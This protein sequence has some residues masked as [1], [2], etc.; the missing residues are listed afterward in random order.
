MR[1]F[2]ILFLFLLAFSCLVPVSPTNRRA[3]VFLPAIP[4]LIG[5]L[6][7]LFEGYRIHIVPA[8]V[9]SGVLMLLALFRALYPGTG[10][11]RPIKPKPSAKRWRKG[12]RIFA[13][14]LLLA[15]SIVLP[16]LFP[17]AELPEPGGPYPVGT[18]LLSFRDGSR[19]EVYSAMEEN[20][21]IPVQVWYPAAG[22]TGRKPAEWI[23][24]RREAALFASYRHLP[25][26]FGQLAL[27]RTHSYWN[28]DISEAEG[29]YPVILFSDG[30]AM[31]TGQNTIQT[32]ELASRGYVV[33][34]VGHPYFDFAC[35]YP[36]GTIAPYSEKLAAMLSA[37]TANALKTARQEYNDERDP[38][39]SRAILRHAEFNK[40]CLR[41]WS[42]D[43]RFIADRIDDM[44]A[45]KISGLFAGKLD[46]QRM[47]AFGHSFGG[48]AAGQLCLEDDRIRAFINLDGSP[49]GDAPD[50][51][52]RQPFMILTHGGDEKYSIRNGYS[53][54]E[55]HFTV[56]EIQ[57]ARHMNFSDFNSLTPVVGRLAG[58]L[59]DVAPDRQTRIVNDYILSFFDR[60]LK[61][62]PVS[63]PDE[64][65][66]KYEEVTL[67]RY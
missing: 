51:N 5:L 29:S 47:G 64:A 9:L 52:I 48:A 35:T 63:L 61:D 16:L 32:E 21:N 38:E 31:F 54:E 2:E 1:Y 57:G 11:G 28:A 55:D 4:F 3:G 15:V 13:M 59:G 66:R 46:I 45:G 12:I 25:D 6:S 39:F 49:F 17:V 10:A 36:D 26:I 67:L 62:K 14:T 40:D 19:K 37:D 43:M 65:S 50:R 53:A 58:F 34:S 23:G 20:R 8:L 30:S 24:G 7:I 42:R 33:F 27:V 41:E 18:M 56:V 22:S 60:H 44:N